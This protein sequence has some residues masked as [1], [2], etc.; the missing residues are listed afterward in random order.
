MRANS[1]MNKIRMILLV[2]SIAVSC[3][4]RGTPVKAPTDPSDAVRLQ[5]LG[6][7]ALLDGTSLA[8]YLNRNKNFNQRGVLGEMS[9]YT[10]SSIPQDASDLAF[11]CGGI[12][13]QYQSVSE[14]TAGVWRMTATN[15]PADAIWRWNFDTTGLEG[16]IL[17][18]MVEFQASINSVSVGCNLTING[19]T[20][21]DY[22]G[23]Y[24]DKSGDC[25]DGKQ[26]V[27]MRIF[28]PEG[29]TLFY[30]YVA[31]DDPSEDSE[32]LE[33]YDY[34]CY[35][36][37]SELDVAVCHKERLHNWQQWKRDFA[38]GTTND[39]NM[40]FCGDSWLNTSSRLLEPLID[41]LSLKYPIRDPGWG[42]FSSAGGTTCEG[43]ADSRV[44]SATRTSGW[45]TYGWGNSLGLTY[46]TSTTNAGEQ[47]NITTTATATQLKIYYEGGTGGEWR[48]RIDGGAWSSAISNSTPG[49]AG[50]TVNFAKSGF[51]ADIETVSGTNNF[52]G[53]VI[54][55]VNAKG[56]RINKTG[57]AGAT[58]NHLNYDQSYRQGISALLTDLVFGMW[59]TNDQYWRNSQSLTDYEDGLMLWRDQVISV[60]DDID[61][62]MATPPRNV[63]TDREGVRPMYLYRDATKYV[64]DIK[65]AAFLN[66]IPLW[67]HDPDEYKDGTTRDY[68][69]S[70]GIHPDTKGT[71]LLVSGL[72][73]MLGL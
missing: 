72:M 33:I 24:L 49:F 68:L 44:S 6:N 39:F 12:F 56:I 2:C 34:K 20:S 70:D 5:D 63:A 58:V 48:Y 4:G 18:F 55:N 17:I 65:G 13:K 61:V 8:R 7:I 16:K 62:I 35:I 9:D 1:T 73:E 66:Y 15:A 50:Y 14:P 3:L 57:E 11:S 10:F 43:W 60:F 41:E 46:T 26:V 45:S 23:K 38:A 40:V 36:E 31:L 64:A 71:K 21:Y 25:V 59:G 27:M 29:T 19:S 52:C 53:A 54:Q 32:W 37:D 51:T 28:I 30:P 47:I 67:G 42:G 69:A 22:G